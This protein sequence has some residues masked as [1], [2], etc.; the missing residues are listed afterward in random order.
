ML[1]ELVNGLDANAD[2]VKDKNPR[3]FIAVWPARGSGQKR[4]VGN[5]GNTCKGSN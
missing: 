5:A 3:K 1:K 4:Y 2:E